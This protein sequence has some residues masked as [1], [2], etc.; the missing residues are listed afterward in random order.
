[1]KNNLKQLRI[2]EGYDEVEKIADE[3]GISASYFYKI[4]KGT[5]KPGITLA[6]KI[7]DKLG[8]TVDNLF[9]NH[10]LDETSNEEQKQI[11]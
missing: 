7:A 5:R 10:N 3:L 11:S 4:E 8:T 1:M 9:F 6:K 2:H